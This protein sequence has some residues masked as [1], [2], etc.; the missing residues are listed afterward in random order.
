MN[1]YIIIATILVVA[2]LAI[3]QME[4]ERKK[5]ELIEE[6]LQQHEEQ[7]NEYEIKTEKYKEKI[8]K[9][10]EKVEK[11]EEKAEATKEYSQ[12]SF[13]ATK[14]APLCS[15]AVAGMCYSGDPTTTA[16]GRTINIGYSVAVDP[17]VIPLGTVFE[18]KIHGEWRKVRADDTGGAI[19]GHVIDISCHSVAQA[20]RWGKREVKVRF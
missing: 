15:E 13:I 18:V 12:Y 11:Y 19:N 4:Q 6:K 16:S 2:V 14:Y 3:F 5:N 20:R 10:K 9:H 8:E 1:N 17:N 7:I